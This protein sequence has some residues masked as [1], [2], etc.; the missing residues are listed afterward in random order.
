M[1]KKKL[2]AL[3]ALTVAMLLMAVP[4]VFAQGVEPTPVSE[5]LEQI[6][7]VIPPAFVI[8]FVTSMLGYLR[9]TEP[10][11]F[12]LVK[13]A[14]TLFISIAVGIITTATGWSYTT[15]LEWLGNAGLTVWIYW[16]VKGISIK[17]GW[18]A[19]EKVA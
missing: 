10:E 5:L 13:F 15:A 11:D 9:N 12:E 2:F 1:L 17:L 8:A 6:G 18:V 14:S 19:V 4:I 16:A 3:T 7:M